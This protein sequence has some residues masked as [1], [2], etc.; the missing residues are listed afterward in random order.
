MVMPGRSWFGASRRLVSVLGAAALAASVFSGRLAEAASTPPAGAGEVV[1]ALVDGK[2]V[3]DI[4][5]KF[6]QFGTS[7]QI[8]L[9]NS[10]QGLVRANDVQGLI[11]KIKEDMAAAPS[12]RTVLWYEQNVSADDPR[13]RTMAAR[14]RTA[15]RRRPPRRP[16]PLPRTMA[17]RTA[18]GGAPGCCCPSR[19]C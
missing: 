12:E 11:N 9:T 15:R 17:A 7:T 13:A 4:T 19:R 14:T 10:R 1:V 8:K 16:R 5:S 3:D 6:Q 18:P 2:T